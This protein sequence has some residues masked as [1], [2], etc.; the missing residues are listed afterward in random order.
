MK[1]FRQRQL[2]VMNIHWDNCKCDIY[3]LDHGACPYCMGE[4]E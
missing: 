3:P 2:Y 1:K 4:E